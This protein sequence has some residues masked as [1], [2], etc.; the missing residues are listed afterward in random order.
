MGTCGVLTAVFACVLGI[1]GLTIGII[2]FVFGTIRSSDV[3]QQALQ[4]AQADPQ[5]IAALGEP[6]ET[7]WWLSGSVS[8]NNDSG[9]ADLSIPLQGAHS[10]GTLYAAADLVGGTWEFYRLEVRVDGRS[11]PIYLLTAVGR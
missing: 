7:K 3:Y 6:I 2:A 5:V 10:S 1:L 8:I 11:E 9:T 4:T